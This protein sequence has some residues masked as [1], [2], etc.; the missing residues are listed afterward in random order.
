VIATSTTESSTIGALNG[1]TPE[2]LCTALAA[3]ECT[4]AEARRLVSYALHAP[5]DPAFSG[6]RQVR[7]AVRE[8]AL[9]AGPVRR[10]RK[11]EARAS[12]VDPFVKYAFETHDGLVVEAVRI[13]LEKT[14]R[15]SVCLS[16][17]VGC[18][19]GCTFCAT[20][21][22]P[23]RRDL[24]AWEIVDQVTHVIED[25]PAGT[26]VHGAVFMGMGE[27]MLNLD[28]VLEAAAVLS[29]PAGHAVG[30]P[31]IT[32]STVGIVPG[33]ERLTALPRPYRLGVS[34]TSAR[35]EQ[36]R[37]LVPIEGRWPI[38]ALMTALRA[39]AAAHGQL[40]MLSYVMLGGVNTSDEDAEA[41]VELV[42]GEPVRVSLIEYNPWA[43]PG[44]GPDPHRPPT[45][46]ELVRFRS[47]LARADVPMIRRYSGGKDVDAACG[48]LAGR[49]GA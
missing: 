28:A 6:V 31:A 43:P 17:Q 10:L 1:V 35:A 34:L 23:V 4:L 37:R 25:L 42:R 47:I 38:P 19:M 7:R 32:I 49:M 36:R 40:V 48:Q 26:H 39:H 45:M 5:G 41:L 12:R 20:A 8:A 13:P 14:G 44:G 9:R 2:R 16:S 22:M 30:A 29:H 15:F 33:I 3:V 18:A 46:E 27:P 24:E 11:L 21:R